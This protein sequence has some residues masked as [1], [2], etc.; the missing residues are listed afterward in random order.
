MI[1]KVV[2]ASYT[3]ELKN[4][5]KKGIYGNSLDIYT[6]YNLVEGAS[7]FNERALNVLI[8][9]LDS[10]TCAT[11]YI[12][13]L[14]KKYRLLIILTGSDTKKAM[15]FFSDDI[16]DFIIKPYDYASDD[17][18]EMVVAITERIKSFARNSEEMNFSSRSSSVQRTRWGSDRFGMKSSFSSDNETLI[19][20]AASTGGTD[21]LYS[22]ITKLPEDMPPILVVQHMPKMFTKQFAKRLDNFS[23]LHVKEAENFETI[24]RGTVYIAEGDYHMILKRKGN[25]LVLES[26]MGKKVNGVRPAADVLFDTVADIMQEKAIGVILTGMGGDGAKGLYKMRINGARTLGQDKDSCVVYGMPKVAFDLGAVQ[27]QFPLDKIPDVLVKMARE[28]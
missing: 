8:L 24:Q 22:I 13:M 7:Y 5:L 25:M 17:A 2:I 9:D 6:A 20:I 28:L 10:G 15:D 3:A 26:I 18:H 27:R 16:K 12:Q 21:A 19:A 4:L 23:K 14:V 11:R 1:T